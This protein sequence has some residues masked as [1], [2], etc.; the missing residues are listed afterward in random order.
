MARPQ[1]EP[2]GE[3]LLP[4]EQVGRCVTEALDACVAGLRDVFDDGLAG[5]YLHGSVAWGAYDPA[6][7]DVDVAV[8]HRSDLSGEQ[9]RAL[10]GLH[11]DHGSRYAASARLDV[12]FVPLRLV[13]TY[14]EDI[15]PYYRDGRFHPFGGGDVNPVMWHTLRERGLIVWGAPAAEF[16]APVSD[17]ELAENMRR[18]LGFLSGRMPDYVRSGA[19]DQVFGVLC[20]CRSLRTLRTRKISGKVSAARWALGE[21]DLR[22]RPLIERALTRYEGG[23]LSGRDPLL[24]KEVEAFAVHLREAAG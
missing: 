9:R 20:L 21:V 11:E 19:R 18:N 5:I 4:V 14:G 6:V 10:A 8:L 23:D 24:E 17:E 16:V 1:E 15:L 12:S 3:T 22:W 13:G 7:S 2:R